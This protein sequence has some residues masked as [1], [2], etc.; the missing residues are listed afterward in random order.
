MLNDAQQFKLTGKIRAI[1]ELSLLRKTEIEWIGFFIFYLEAD[2]PWNVCSHV[3]MSHS[4]D[5]SYSVLCYRR[6]FPRPS[7]LLWYLSD[8]WPEHPSW[9]YARPIHFNGAGPD[10][11]TGQ[12]DAERQSENKLKIQ[13]R[14]SLSSSVEKRECI[15]IWCKQE[16]QSERCLWSESSNSMPGIG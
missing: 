9:L 2:P 7:R 1:S 13:S 6:I 11:K 16:A 8:L 10:L 12:S 4:P 14:L 5:H 3:L 15:G